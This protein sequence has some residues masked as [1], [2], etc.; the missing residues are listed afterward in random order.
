MKKQYSYEI[1]TVPLYTFPEDIQIIISEY[2]SR[3]FKLSQ[4]ISNHKHFKKIVNESNT[5]LMEQHECHLLVFE[6]EHQLDI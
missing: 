1:K 2:A 5:K 4:F 3:G 6:Y